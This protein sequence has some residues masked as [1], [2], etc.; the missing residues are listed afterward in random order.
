MSLDEDL[1]HRTT[2]RAIYILSTLQLNFQVITPQCCKRKCGRHKG[3]QLI[4]NLFQTQV[5]IDV[6][7]LVHD[8]L[9]LDRDFCS[10]SRLERC[11]FLILD[12]RCGHMGNTVDLQG[13]VFHVYH[14]VV[15]VGDLI[16]LKEED[17]YANGVVLEVNDVGYVERMQ[18]S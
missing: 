16:S 11:L 13:Q 15:V 5:D 2:I 9:D 3:K 8:V 4:Y 6:S 1:M 14:V 18:V 17:V 10:R 7:F 12:L